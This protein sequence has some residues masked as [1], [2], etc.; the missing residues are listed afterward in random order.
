MLYRLILFLFVF[1]QIVP[2][3]AQQT[4]N[5][6]EIKL[7]LEKL[8]VL[9]SVLYFAAHPDDENTRLI[10]W[11]ANEKKYRTSYL[12]LTRG[13]GGQNLI[14][15]ELGIE[16]GLIRTQE[17]LAARAI[18]GGEQ[19]F[20]SAYD[21]GFSKTYEETFAF[22]EKEETLREA[23]WI[24]RKLRPDV[25]INRFPP[26]KRGGHGHHQASAILSHEAFIA[27]ADPNRFPEQLDKVDV[28]Q[29]KRLLW[30]TANFGGQNN[31]SEDQLQIEIGHYN[32]LLGASYGEIA[33]QSRSQHKS[34]GFGALPTRGN[35]TEYF[36]H[37]AGEQAEE[38]LL[39][40]VITDWSRVENSQG[41]AQL[42]TR[43]NNEFAVDAPQNS[44]DDLVRLHGM[45]KGVNNAYWRDVKLQEIEDL[46][47]ACAGLHIDNYT[48]RPD[49]VVGTSFEAV[50]DIIVRNPDVKVRILSIDGNTVRKDLTPNQVFTHSH[51][52]VFEVTTQP[53]WLVK[54]YSLGKF[55]V[56]EEDFGKAQNSYFPRTQVDIEI[57]GLAISLL[58]PTVYR[59]LDPVHGEI[60]SPVRVIPKLTA[61]T[62][63]TTMLLNQGEEK[64]VAVTFTNHGGE[65]SHVIQ[66]NASEGVEVSPMELTLDFKG[67]SSITKLFTLAAS[68][69]NIDSGTVSF[70][71]DDEPVTQYN[72]IAYDH[73]P[74]VSW[75]PELQIKVQPIDLQVPVKR[76]AYVAGAGDLIAESLQSIGVQVDKLSPEQLSVAVLEPYDAV[77]FGVRAYNVHPQLIG[78]TT[79]LMEYVAN[80]GVVLVQYNVSGRFSGTDIGPFP[81][82][83]TRTRVTEEDSDVKILL[84]YDPALSYPNKIEQA[85][86]EGW[87]QERGLYFAENAD[88]RYRKPLA[89]HD[90]DE[91]ESDGS[92]LIANHG[93]GKFVYTSISFFRQLP[94]GIPGA[95][96]L[97]VNLLSKEQ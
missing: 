30:N 45:V 95:Y 87:V 4:K 36:E 42:I 39:D 6:A 86:F 52:T 89:M 1:F 37:V 49:V 41:I 29:A 63:T 80:G 43:L 22:W 71:N 81:F 75:L 91:R 59:Y 11:L 90:K 76:I 24:I 66:V 40:G 55:D 88:G 34:Q 23:V 13:D 73:I 65:K 61:S 35:S 62:S 51:Q 27:A 33:A 69:T 38:T 78:N 26:D 77:V 93:K 79:E 46:I 50:Q 28:W 47:L 58:L 17:L 20:S 67:K 64:A 12:S 10:A 3:S 44:I 14:G 31:T 54:P 94:A 21:F 92:L 82:D 53:F 60:Q 19:Y 32:P 48:K 18:D 70:T 72:V 84:P 57:H 83:I 9:G 2:L 15:N 8:N 74:T 85:D 68:D 5:A 96:R 97:F 16:L 56:D 7:R 25:I